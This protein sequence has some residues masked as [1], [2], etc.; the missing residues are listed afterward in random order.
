MC[1]NGLRV[2]ARFLVDQ[3][4]AKPGEFTVATRAGLRTVWCP[5]DGPVTVDMGE[6]VFPEV[7]EVRVHVGERSWPATAV[8]MPNPHAVSFVEQLDHAGDLLQ[9]PLVDPPEAFPQGVNVEFVVDRGPGHLALRVHERGSGETRSC[10][11][12]VCAVVAA[13]M[14]AGRVPPGRC[15]VDVPGGRLEI[16]TSGYDRVLMTGPAELVARGQWIA[17]K[18]WSAGLPAWDAVVD[19]AGLGIGSG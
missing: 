19:G 15:L 8:L 11:T 9:A 4:L 2:F 6:A 13:A 18:G 17:D 14:R 16:E 7:G 10:G 1:G 12:G 5:A 3:G